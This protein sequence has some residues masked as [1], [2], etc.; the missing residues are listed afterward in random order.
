ATVGIGGWWTGG[1]GTPCAGSW[2]ADRGEA[3]RQ[4]DDDAAQGSGVPPR[5]AWRR[6]LGRCADAR[7]VAGRE[8]SARWAG[9]DRRRGTRLR[10]GGARRPTGDRRSGNRGVAR[11]AACG[12]LDRES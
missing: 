7:L 2:R 10:R 9:D 8:G 5:P 12:A 1:G 3:A 6:R 11:E 4:A